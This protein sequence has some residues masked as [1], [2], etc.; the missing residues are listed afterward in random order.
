MKTTK[1]VIAIAL[2]VLML[3]LAVPFAAYAGTNTLTVQCDKPGYTYSVYKVADFNETTG[4]FEN[5]KPTVQAEIDKSTDST[6]KVLEKVDELSESD[7]GDAIGSV[8]FTASLTSQDF[9]NLDPG[10]YYV[11][12]TGRAISNKEITQESIVPIPNGSN[13]YTVDVSSKIKEKGEPSV[14]K[15]IQITNADGTTSLVTERTASQE[16]TITYVLTAEITGTTQNKLA[17]YIIGDQMDEDNLSL[18]D[19]AIK[20]VQLMNK[21]NKV[22]DLGYTLLSKGDAD[23]TSTKGY[24]YS[25]GVSLNST[26]LE[27]NAF[28][29]EGYTVQVI[30]TTKLNAN[31]KKIGTAIP[32]EDGLKYEN[33]SGNKNEVKGKEVQVYTY[34]VLVNK[35]DADSTTTKLANAV[36]G[37]F[38]DQACTQEIERKTTGTDGTA[39]FDYKF[40]AGTYY[41]KEITAPQGYNLNST[42]FTVTIEKGSSSLSNGVHNSTIIPNTKAK[43]PNTGGAGTL[44]F[45][46]VG[47]AL[48]IAAGILLVVVLK[49][50]STK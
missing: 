41:V 11:K 49:K 25:F 4:R 23:L 46:L 43:L 12:C 26:A 19:V 27:D 38:K 28:Y 37:I 32:N 29:T 7:L 8:T 13:L 45:T 1:R 17:K 33:K 47:G 35:V 31:V 36:I 50:R 40:A 24:N 14:D 34:K 16:D 9:P 18:A 44:A 5:A 10:M 15:K 48:V 3:A 6:A 39:A 21:T 22:K 20:S 42:V 2:T 30:F